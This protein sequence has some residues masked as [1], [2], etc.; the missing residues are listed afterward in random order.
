MWPASRDLITLLAKREAVVAGLG[1]LF[2]PVC[3]VKREAVSVGEHD[4]GPSVHPSSLAPEGL[5]APAELG[6]VGLRGTQV[7]GSGGPP[8]WGR[9]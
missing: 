6:V 2:G 7:G 9:G 1:R 3:A 4:A 8:Q 5:H